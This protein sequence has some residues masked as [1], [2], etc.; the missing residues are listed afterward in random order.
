M[1]A[2]SDELGEHT[3]TLNK[4]AVDTLLKYVRNF[5]QTFGNLTRQGS[6]KPASQIPQTKAP[7]PLYT[8]VVRD[9]QGQLDNVGDSIFETK[10]GLRASSLAVTSDQAF[11]R[12]AQAPVCR[13]AL[14][15]VEQA[16]KQGTA[17]CVQ[18]L[19]GGSGVL[20]I[21]CEHP[22]GPGQS[23]R[24]IEIPRMGRRVPN[25]RF[26]LIFPFTTSHEKLF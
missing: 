22:A 19:A 9:M 17:S 8:A 25:H 2:I 20:E 18:S 13:K 7:S 10:G 23:Q 11:E 15:K 21:D 26:W 14:N 24:K 3:K 12:F 1:K 16:I 6:S 4:E 5:N